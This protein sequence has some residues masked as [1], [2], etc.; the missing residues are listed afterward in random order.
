MEK[1]C[2]RC[3]IVRHLR[4]GQRGKRGK[5][6]R[7]EGREGEGIK[8]HKISKERREIRLP[9]E[10]GKDSRKQMLTESLIVT[11]DCD[12]L[13]SL[14][15]V[16]AEMV[17]QLPFLLSLDWGIATQGFN[18]ASNEEMS[19]SLEMFVRRQSHQ[20]SSQQTQNVDRE[21]SFLAVDLWRAER[22]DSN[23]QE[24]ADHDHKSP[25]IRVQERKVRGGQHVKEKMNQSDKSRD[26]TRRWGI[27][28]RIK[29]RSGQREKRNDWVGS[30]IIRMWSIDD[31]VEASEAFSFLE[32]PMRLSVNLLWHYKFDTSHV[33]AISCQYG[34][35]MF[36]TV[37]SP[38]PC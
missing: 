33:D 2:L 9:V 10:K 26:E 22:L 16:T 17:L 25:S 8:E 32:T 7:E 30:R 35:V 27:L 12:A 28:E 24:V 36:A 5:E 34:T 38:M 6:G 23:D 37:S 13:C 11:A 29:T 21:S 15:R 19:V 18:G 20:N 3:L 1:I 31:F 4:Q 14:F